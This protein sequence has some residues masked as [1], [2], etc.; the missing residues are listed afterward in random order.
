[1]EAASCKGSCGRPPVPCNDAEGV[2]ADG[3]S[4]ACVLPRQVARNLYN[5]VAVV[6]PGSPD[7]LECAVPASTPAHFHVSCPLLLFMRPI[8]SGLYCFDRA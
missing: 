7:G 3:A 1:M 8:F 2:R 6:D 5:L 4:V